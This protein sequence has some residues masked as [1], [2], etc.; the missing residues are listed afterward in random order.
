MRFSGKY[1]RGLSLIL[2]L[3][4]FVSLLTPVCARTPSPA[5]G[6]QYIK[7]V[8]FTAPAPLM[9]TLIGLDVAA[10]SDPAAPQVRWIEALAYLAARCCGNFKNHKT[11]TLNKLLDALKAG[12]TMAELTAD[13][14]DYPYYF[15][16]Y[17][18]VLGGL[19]GEYEVE[20]ELG[21]LRVWEKKYGLRAYFP[22]ACGFDFSDFDD[23]GASRSYGYKRPH[24]GHDLM[25]LTGTPV[26]ACESGVVEELGWNQYGGWR[27]GIRSF[28][29]RR[30][31]YYAHLR[32]NRPYA[33]GLTRG[34][35]VMAGDVIGYVGH[36]GYSA[37]ENVNGVKESHLHWGLQLIFDPSQKDGDNQIWIDLYALARLLEGRRGETLRDPETGE[38]SRARGYREEIPTDRFVP[39][40]KAE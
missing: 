40:P 26:V 23:F 36:T 20:T 34:D 27:V 2:A 37:K 9:K 6:C 14:K 21:G 18:A 15:E 32:Q 10:H 38:R 29:G 30:Y 1:R 24:L 5:P 8:E 7:W 3:T 28:D 11:S 31:W 17:S 12:K 22:L 16:A 25:A 35:V 19:V 33:E 39:A 13:L 4:L